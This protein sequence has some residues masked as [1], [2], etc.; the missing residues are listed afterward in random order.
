MHDVLVILCQD[1]VI[2]FAGAKKISYL[3]QVS[4]TFQRRDLNPFP[5]G[6]SIANT[7]IKKMRHAISFFSRVK[8]TTRRIWKTSSIISNKVIKEKP[9]ASSRK[10]KSKERSANSGRTAWINIT[11]PRFDLVRLTQQRGEQSVPFRLISALRLAIYLRWKTR[12]NWD[13]FARHARSPANST[14]NIWKIKLSTSSIL[15]EY[16]TR[17]TVHPHSPD[18]LQSL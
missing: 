3:K 5:I 7:Q 1:S 12:K 10:I 8:T 6:R 2:I 14:V 15:N 16:E 11:S 17:Q 9:W 13:W 18:V 4:K